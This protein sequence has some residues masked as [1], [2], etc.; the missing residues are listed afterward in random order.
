MPTAPSI[1]VHVVYADAQSEA[2]IKL[3][4]NAGIDYRFIIAD[5]LRVDYVDPD[6]NVH[7]WTECLTG[8][9]RRACS[10]SPFRSADCLVPSAER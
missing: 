8:P 9:R 7:T 3:L 5:K 10:R 1:T 4:D 6:G 2:T